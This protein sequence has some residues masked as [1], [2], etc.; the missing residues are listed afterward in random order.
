MLHK[1]QHTRSGSVL[2]G[3]RPEWLSKY[4]CYFYV[5]CLTISISIW[6]LQSCKDPWNENK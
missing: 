4:L 6:V 3:A 2:H 5:Q 1:I